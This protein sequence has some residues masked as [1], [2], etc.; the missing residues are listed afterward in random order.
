MLAGTLSAFPV[1]NT[2]TA[3]DIRS[4]FPVNNTMTGDDHP[5]L[6]E[7]E[8][9]RLAL[10]PAITDQAKQAQ[11]A[12]ERALIDLYLHTLSAKPI[13]L[14]LCEDAPSFTYRIPKNIKCDLLPLEG[15][16]SKV[17]VTFWYTDVERARIDGY[18][19]YA[20]LTYIRKSHFFFGGYS[21]SRTDTAVPVSPSECARMARTSK[22]PRNDPM[23]RLEDNTFGTNLPMDLDYDWP[24]TR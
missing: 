19:C 10:D 12:Y 14:Y 5:Y 21:E 3:D 22:S 9:G 18:Y 8:F 16:S 15:A 11:I 24:M 2:M 7:E 6:R 23:V 13:P 17:K 20:T 4:A 1:N